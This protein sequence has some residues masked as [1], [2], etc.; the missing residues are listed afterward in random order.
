MSSRSDP[1]A[2]EQ[3]SLHRGSRAVLKGLNFRVEQGS[4]SVLLGP[5][6]SGKTTLLE[7]IAGLLAPSEGRI[8]RG[9]ELLSKEGVVLVPP[10]RRGLGMVF[11]GLA[12]WPHMSVTQ[13]LSFVSRGGAV[14]ELIEAVGLTERRDAAPHELSG[15]EQQRLAIARAL[16]G[17]AGLVLFDEP[18]SQLDRPLARRLAQDLIL[19]SAERS[20]SS[21][22][23]THDPA[24]ALL[25]GERLL[26]LDEG[27]LVFDGDAQ[28]ARRDPGS[29][30]LAEILDLGALLPGRVIEGAR[31]DCLLGEVD[32]RGGKFSAGAAVELLV[33]PSDLRVVGAGAEG[34]G[35]AARV[36]GLESL[37]PSGVTLLFS[38]GERV[39]RARSEKSWPPLA[40]I[41]L[42]AG[43]PLRAF[44]SR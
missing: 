10:E 25:L 34:A 24:E 11:Q 38:C 19:L 12:L 22:I 9:A 2:I 13:T 7:L 3:L 30:R 40:E 26:V 20:M 39:L 43:G 18:F 14:D 1:L 21:L 35:V 33:R 37:D 41:R 29:A 42:K 15:G 31:A 44:T 6:G 17:G 5:S 23:V 32:I 36:T 16:A 28:A 8:S 4:R 27:R